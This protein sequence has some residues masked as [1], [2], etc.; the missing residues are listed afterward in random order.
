MNV[1][2]WVPGVF[3]TQ[4]WVLAASRT[5]QIPHSIQVCWRRALL[6]PRAQLLDIYRRES[7]INKHIKIFSTLYFFFFSVALGLS[8][9]L[10]DPSLYAWASLYL[11][12]MG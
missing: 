1:G 8:C 7:S 4:F 9:G 3:H 11:W 10:W 5:G 2:M 6:P 12:C